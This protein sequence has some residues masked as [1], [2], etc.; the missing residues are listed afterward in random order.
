VKRRL[1]LIFPVVFWVWV[2]PAAAADL[3][4]GYTYWS[5]YKPGTRVSFRSVTTGSGSDRNTALTF[6]VKLVDPDRAI[7]VIK[8][9]SSP[10]AKGSRPGMESL[11]EFKASAFAREKEDLFKGMLPVNIAREIAEPEAEIEKGAEDLTVNGIRIRADRVRNIYESSGVRNALTMW[12][13]D[14]IPGK[15]VKLVREIKTGSSM[16][17]EEVQAFDFAALPAAEG[18]IARLRAARKPAWVEVAAQSLLMYETRFLDDMENLQK[19]AAAWKKAMSSLVPDA[20]NNNLNEFY[21]DLY[22]YREKISQLKKHWAEDRPAIEAGLE[23]SELEKIRPMLK[24]MSRY[25]EALGKPL[26]WLD[27]IP[28]MGKKASAYEEAL[29]LVEVMKG[30]ESELISAARSLKAESQKLRNLKLK[31][32]R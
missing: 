10:E 28:E 18:E 24:A 23:T 22:S 2:G 14:E 19:S 32:L 8:E 26:E 5:S 20:P 17:R 7:L 31:V 25:A 21:K 16:L 12:L 3:G 27:R 4:Q 13:S 9:E 6:S 11:I 15:L 30:E 29:A 1:F